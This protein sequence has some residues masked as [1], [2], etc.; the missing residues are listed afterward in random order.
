M[1]GAECKKLKEHRQVS[2]QANEAGNQNL[3]QFTYC[4]KRQ[5]KAA[6]SYTHKSG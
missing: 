6:V 5:M 4:K 2:R 1:S 3:L